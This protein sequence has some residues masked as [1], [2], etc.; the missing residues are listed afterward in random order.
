MILVTGGAGYIGS[1]I[2]LELI[3]AGMSPI[4][5]DNFSTSSDAS[6]KAIARF[7]GQEIPTFNGDIRD[8]GFVRKLFQR[9]DI[10]SVIHLAGLKVLTESRADPLRYFDNN[11]SG[12]TTLCQ[13]MSDMG[14]KQLVFSSSASIYAE[15]NGLAL[16]EVAP[17]QVKNPYSHS[18]QMAE[19]ILQCLHLADETWHI[20]ILRYFN[21]VGAH[22]TGIIGESP[23]ATA[24]NLIPAII[25]VAQSKAPYLSVFGDDYDTHDGTAIRDYLHV[26]DLA[27]AAYCCS[28]RA[29]RATSSVANL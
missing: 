24:T 21:P 20:S 23:T 1:H 5:I 4:V 25:R 16:T 26:Q 13:V 15:A 29:V 12:T 10:E 11:V 28:S 14:C 7:T 8:K 27:K 22:H 18:K 3:L 19:D 6:L 9:F 17:I 2:C